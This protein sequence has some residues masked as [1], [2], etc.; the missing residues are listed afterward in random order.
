VAKPKKQ[1]P[2]AGRH[3]SRE[4]REEKSA[5][6]Q[7]RVRFLMTLIATSQYVT[8]L[9]ADQY[10]REW[11]LSVGYVEQ[12][13]CE[14]AARLREK[15]FTDDLIHVSVL[16]TLQT[17]AATAM[18]ASAEAGERPE[19]EDPIDRRLRIRRE[20]D[21]RGER[22]RI[23]EAAARAAL[24][25]GGVT[26]RR[27]RSL[28][29]EIEAQAKSAAASADRERRAGGDGG[30]RIVVQYAGDVAREPEPATY[31]RTPDSPEPATEPGAPGDPTRK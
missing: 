18:A 9:T 26:E 4:E 22:A 5:K 7:E 17:I 29:A 30:V 1:K 12:L 10:A 21:R 24:A 28:N 2:S 25:I 23:L 8:H 20:L 15:V 3:S 11:R 16:T 6:K 31:A 19:Q 27:R 14:A 13:A